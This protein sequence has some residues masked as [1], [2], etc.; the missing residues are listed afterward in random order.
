MRIFSSYGPI[1]KELHYHAPREKLIETGYTRLV[2]ENPKQGGHYITVWAPRQCGKTWVTQ[3]AFHRVRK[4]GDF[5]TGIF[6]IESLKNVK[7]EQTVVESFIQKMTYEF[8][9]EFPPL[10]KINEI[11]RLFTK[12]YFQKPVILVVDEF[13]ALEEEF[14]NGFAAVFRDMYMNRSNQQDKE[15][16]D[17]TYLLHGL[18]LVG[19]RSVLGIENE[20]GSPFNV[21]RSLHIPNLTSE[22]VTGMFRWYEKESGQKVKDDVID[23]LFYETRGQPGLTCWLGEL[24]TET[25][26]HEP[27]KPIDIDDFKESYAAAAFVLPNNNILNLISKAKVSPY[28][29]SVLE[30]FK[31]DE[32]IPFK[33]DDPEINY[34]YMNGLIDLDKVG[35]TEYYVKFSS[36]FVQ[37]RLFNYFSGELFDYMGKLVEPFENLD[38]VL[39]SSGVNLRHLMKCYGVYLAK[40]REWLL[41][42][43]P[44]RKDLRVFEA[45]YHFNVYMYLHKFFNVRGGKVYPEFP[46]GNGKIDLII[47]YE[48]RTYGL[49]L[50]SF[51]H[52]GMYKEALKQAAK[53]GK[54]LSLKEIGLV[55]FVESID[56]GNREKY[57]KDYFDEEAGVTVLPIFVESGK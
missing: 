44:R 23:R 5:H 21:Q 51:S 19:V 39:P 11:P 8:E 54:R 7:D 55:F 48:G 47:Q 30:L 37:K 2:G 1:N 12:Q 33:F 41:K 3:Q 25:Y 9:I 14:I 34:L 46:T 45:V 40:N 10:K 38:Q 31:T 32:K 49:E 29:E 28:K 18:A 13:D 16:M 20:K 50:K 4:T 56:A 26:N 43:A 36:P 6:S 27:G 53:Y 57:E 52:E 35:R 24:M 42:E 17:K 22:E 15:S